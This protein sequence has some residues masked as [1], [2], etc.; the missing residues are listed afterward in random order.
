MFTKSVL[1][2]AG[3]RAI[4]YKD[5]HRRDKNPLQ[6]V[7]WTVLDYFSLETFFWDRIKRGNSSPIMQQ[8]QAD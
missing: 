6:A 1:A 4:L 5:T 8:R 7:K 2:K 3:H